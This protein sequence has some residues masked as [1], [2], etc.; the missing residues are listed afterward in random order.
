MGPSLAVRWSCSGPSRRGSRGWPHSR[1]F[2]FRRA[3]T[4]WA[5]ARRWLLLG[6]Q[7]PFLARYA[8]RDLPTPDLDEDGVEAVRVWARWRYAEPF[9]RG[10]A[11]LMSVRVAQIGAGGQN[12]SMGIAQA[13]G[14]AA[15]EAGSG[16]RDGVGACEPVARE[17]RAP[18]MEL[19]AGFARAVD[20][21]GASTA[22]LG[23]S[24]NRS[25]RPRA[26]CWPSPTSRCAT[27]CSGRVGGPEGHGVGP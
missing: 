2:H 7:G 14:V 27:F 19:A 5:R 21:A 23:S 20:A 9:D 12:G 8:P 17:A 24:E 11:R 1:E 22:F 18:A 16:G 26:S 25:S 15:S 6:N 3:L 4:C 13:L 10:L